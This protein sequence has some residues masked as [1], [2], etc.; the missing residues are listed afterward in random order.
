MVPL[1][2]AWASRKVTGAQT[3]AITCCQMSACVGGL[4]GPVL[5]GA[6]ADNIGLMPAIALAGMLVAQGVMPMF[7][8]KITRREGEFATS[9]G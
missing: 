5:T 4:A 7:L 3:V 1:C 8:E 2:F 9:E 6:I